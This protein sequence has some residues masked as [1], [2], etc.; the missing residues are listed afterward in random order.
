M[1]LFS[2]NLDN[3]EIFPLNLFLS[4]I[5]IANLFGRNS[6]NICIIFCFG[7]SF[8]LSLRMSPTLLFGN[9]SILIVSPCDQYDDI[10]SIEGP[11]SPLC[12]NNIPSSKYVLPCEIFALSDS[13]L[14]SLHN[15]NISSVKVNGTNAGWVSIIFK[16]NCPAMLYPKSVAPILGI[17]SPPVAITKDFEIYLSLSL[18]TMY[19]LSIFSIDSTL[20]LFFIRTFA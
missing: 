3:S 8:F 19:S 20:K 7:F 17:D 18:I 16:L 1:I 15:D 9:K 2:D 12:V 14:N 6:D 10:C 5:I 11:L 13:P 4:Q